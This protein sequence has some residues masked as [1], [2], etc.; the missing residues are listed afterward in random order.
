LNRTV[1]LLLVLMFVTPV[2]VLAQDKQDKGKKSASSLF[3]SDSEDLLFKGDFRLGTLLEIL[4]RVGLASVLG[5]AVAV[6][7]LR[8]YRRQ[9]VDD[10]LKTGLA[11]R[12]QILICAAGALMVIV[13][14]SSIARAFG[15]VGL[16][17]FV[18]FR[19][20]MKD[21]TDLAVLFLLVGIGMA[22]GLASYGIAVYGTVTIV[23]VL[24]ALE[25][26]HSTS[27]VTSDTRILTLTMKGPEELFNKA[28]R[29][30][31]S[32]P[33]VRLHSFEHKPKKEKGKIGMWVQPDFDVEVLLREVGRLGEF[34]ELGFE[35]AG[36]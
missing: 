10:P 19:T 25:L 1:I 27:R 11:I 13:I 22:C 18:R 33:A 2:V 6:H 21:P 17:S 26:R 15:L 29:H 31:R 5:A 12:A 20:T 24:A 4:Q 7:P 9:T 36:E 32:L 16:G 8:L 3:V 28:L 30:V 23:L 34:N 14:G 35:E